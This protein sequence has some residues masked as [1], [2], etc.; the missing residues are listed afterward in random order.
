M[1]WMMDAMERVKMSKEPKPRLRSA[2]TTDGLIILYYFIF[3]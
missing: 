1:Q 2:L 3:T